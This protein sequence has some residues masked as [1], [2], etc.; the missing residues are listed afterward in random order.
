M[1]RDATQLLT[2]QPTFDLVEQAFQSSGAEAVF[3][4]LAGNARQSNNYRM[5]FNIRL[6]QARYRLGMPLIDPDPVPHLTDEQRPIYDQACREAALETGQLLLENGDIAGAWPYFRAIGE[7]GPVAAAIE[8][9]TASDATVDSVIDIAFKEGVNPRKG[10]EL[11]LEQ[12]GICSAITWFGYN[13]EYESR[14]KSLQLLV[15]TLYEQVASALKESI[16]AAEGVAP[17]TNDVVELIAGRPWLFEGMSSYVDSTH[18]TSALRFTPELEDTTSLRMAVQLSDYGQL[19]NPM[20]HFRGDS[21]FEDTYR[22][23]AIYLRALLEENV[24]AAIAH[25]RRK[26]EES[27]DPTTSAEVLIDLLVRLQRYDEAVHASLEY[28]PDPKA[29]SSNCPSVLQLCQ[30]AGDHEKLRNVS[31]EHGDLVGFAAGLIQSLPGSRR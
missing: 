28:F 27:P 4:V 18:L 22:D 8:K 5:L 21:P 3:D 11:I 25:I 9:V 29:P 17:A 7:S 16:I 26:V 20:F 31:R 12:R 24:D 13:R 10:F 14:Q 23:H 2:D 19:L 30:M 15:R 1:D 6:M